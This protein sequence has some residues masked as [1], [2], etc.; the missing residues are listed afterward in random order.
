MNAEAST[1]PGDIFP[2]SVRIADYR[3]VNP[4]N[5][6]H[7]G[8]VSLVGQIDPYPLVSVVVA[9]CGEWKFLKHCLESICQQ[10]YRPFEVIVIDN[11][12]DKDIVHVVKETFPEIHVIRTDQNLGFAGGY[13]VGLGAA[14][15]DYIAIINDD[16]VASPGWLSAMVR[17]AESDKELGAIG[18]IIS[19]GNNPQLLD[20]CGIGMSLDG[21]SRQMMRGEKPPILNR[22]KEVLAV[23]GCA[24]MFRSLALEQVGLFDEDF[25]A[26]CEDTDLGLRLR[27]AG[28]K[29][30]IAPD[31]TVTHYYSRTVG[32]FSLKK[33]FWV[34]RNHFWLVAKNFPLILFPIV[35]LTTV[36]RTF[37]QFVAFVIRTQEICQF[38]AKAGL[39]D[40]FFT[41]ANA[42]MSALLGLPNMVRKRMASSSCMRISSLK[43]CRLIFSFRMS[44]WTVI[45]GG[46][47][48]GN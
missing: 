2:C 37:L 29:A 46:K 15:G 23:S 7:Y 25:F 32:K 31:A 14:K 42:N 47:C 18:S 1:S 9:T 39:F 5:L 22:P 20:S 38:T 35:F 10:N 41:I 33:V 19:D 24:C 6:I 43:M 21:M 4:E 13:N 36:W 30:A 16:A 12:S 44:T 27:W 8:Q 26:Y 17:L 48:A 34:E 3:D 11:G 40:T 28:W 45:T